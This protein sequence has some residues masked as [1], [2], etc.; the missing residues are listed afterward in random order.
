MKG[1][2]VTS[3][4]FLSALTLQAEDWPQYRGP[5]QNGISKETGWQKEWPKEDPATV[6]KAKVG[7]G[8]SSFSVADGR[9][10]TTGNADEKDTVW[11]F[12]ADTG[13]VIWKHTFEE[14][15]DPKYFEGGT[16]A[17][18]TVDG[19]VV[20]SISRRGKLFCFEAATGAIKWQKDVTQ[21]T[22]AALP[23]WGFAGSPVVLGDLLLL[24]AGESGAA[25]KKA[26]GE[27][28]WFSDTEFAGYST[29]H[30]IKKGA[31]TLAIFSSGNAFIIRDAVTGK[32]SSRFKWITKYGVNAADPIVE[33]N[34]IF[35]SSGYGKGACVMDISTSPPTELWRNTEMQNQ[36]NPCVL[37][38]GHLY[39][40]SGD[41]DDSGTTLKC[42]DF[43]TGEAK[44]KY[45]GVGAGS[46][47]AAD[48]HL[49][50]LT[51][52]GELLVGPVSSA[53]FEPVLQLQ[54]LGGK[55]WT[56][57]VLANGR[58]YARNS[59]GDVVCV[60]LRPKK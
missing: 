23:T 14:P 41:E 51:A 8:F 34:H 47:T 24:N 56:A 44:W 39:G 35:V 4:V 7:M 37:I 33:G 17:T 32:E 57:P 43:K 50:V 16:F 52:R 48:G 1:L 18:P 19:A 25:L 40:C 22:G 58:L 38:D 15:L 11:C 9:V 49:I 2:F 21:L 55:C 31:D 42:V 45:P 3:L 20:Y 28:A 53:D 10:Y 13:E 59:E 46:V 26:T 12:H 5:D 29:P 36:L 60:D 54:I 27:L 6:W 30:L